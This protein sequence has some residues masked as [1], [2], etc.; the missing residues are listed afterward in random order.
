MMEKDKKLKF[1]QDRFLKA[2]SAYSGVLEKLSE[3]EQLYAGT[4]SILKNVNAK[5]N[6]KK[7]ADMVRNIIY[8]LVE[9]QVDSN[10]PYPKVR[11]VREKDVW[12]AQK[13]EDKIRCETD[14]LPMEQDNDLAERL[15]YA[16]G[17]CGYHIE[18]DNTKRTHSEVGEVWVSVLHP[19]Q[20]IP[21][22]GVYDVQKMD[23]LFLMVAQT[24]AA[25]LQSYGVDLS[26]SQEEYP[27][28]RGENFSDSEET[29]TQ[30]IGYYR[31]DTGGIGRI[32]WACDYLLE[33]IPDF[34]ARR[35]RKCRKCGRVEFGEIC[36]CGSRD[37][38]YQVSR[39]EVLQADLVLK[40]GENQ[41]VVPAGTSIPYY[42]PDMFPV[43][44][45][46][47]VS[48]YGSFLG[49]S[50]IDAISDQ[51]N[52]IKKIQTKIME[53]LVRGGSFITM[54]KDVKA[55]FDGEELNI[56]RLE[57]AQE[58]SLIDVYNMQP[59]INNDVQYAEKLYEEAKQIL[60]VTDSFLGRRDTTATS[61]KAKQISVQQTTGRL[62]SK[63]IMKANA[64]AEIYEL[65]I[66]FLIAFSDE[67]RP[68]VH[69]DLDGHDVFSEFSK[70]DFLEQDSAGEWFYNV[71]FLF[72]CDDSGA[73]AANRESMWQET[74]MNFQQGA[75]GDVS[76]P[77]TQILFWHFLEQQHYPNAGK[78]K[79][80]LEE[81]LQQNETQQQMMAENQMLTQ[82]N[83][84]AKM[85][86][87]ELSQQLSQRAMQDAE[88]AAALSGEWM[89][90]N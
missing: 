52:A 55:K 64:Y 65:M 68:V 82:E 70:Y 21:Q 38:S 72:S 4:R 19:K 46:R 87:D 77:N 81:R 90:M 48:K 7:K 60:G 69:K 88:E 89:N 20:I 22:P 42:K 76:D 67:A 12:R 61:G 74:R 39:A 26:E 6:P 18:W 17:G 66:K 84:A 56:L 9:A 53:K 31:N 2:K 36:L 40:N 10:I 85:R 49:A 11:A 47:N 32:S 34:Q 8:E 27:E 25:I 33:D 37:F 54:G 35:V 73:L 79:R 3:Y 71:D 86:E 59:P 78:M 75:F 5:S 63:R 16:L 45:R 51:Q 62:E 14:R 15:V 41:V 1:W 29:V 58:K 13:C 80:I 83:A 24:K 57:N 23:Y 44:I 28:I 30:I 43:V 50:D